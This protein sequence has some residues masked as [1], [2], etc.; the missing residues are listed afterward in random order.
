MRGGVVH[1]LVEVDHIIYDE[2]D[3]LFERRYPSWELR[4]ND[5]KLCLWVRSDPKPAQSRREGT[6]AW[7]EFNLAGRVF[8]FDVARPGAQKPPPVDRTLPAPNEVS[9]S[10]GFLY[11][12]IDEFKRVLSRIDLALEP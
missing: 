10:I 11:E 3:D 6:R 12:S 1:T 8:G 9:S 7:V 2:S 5:D 4:L